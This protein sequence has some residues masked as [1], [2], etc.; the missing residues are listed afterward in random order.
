MTSVWLCEFETEEQ[1][2]MNFGDPLYKW[3][4][5][6]TGHL[7][8]VRFQQ[9]EVSWKLHSIQL[10]IEMIV[11]TEKQWMEFGYGLTYSPSHII[12]LKFYKKLERK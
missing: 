10:L 11:L 8:N 1:L 5:Y 7:E 9:H 12:Y 3:K 2:Q 6:F 4:T